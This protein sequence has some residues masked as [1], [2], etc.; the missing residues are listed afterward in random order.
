MYVNPLRKLADHVFRFFSG[1]NTSYL[2][3]TNELRMTLDL[4][5]DL[6]AEYRSLGNISEIKNREFNLNTLNLYTGEYLKHA[7]GVYR[8]ME[9]TGQLQSF[10]YILENLKKDI[11]NLTNLAIFKTFRPTAKTT[12]YLGLIAFAQKTGEL[13]NAYLFLFHREL[14]RNVQTKNSR[15]S[16]RTFA[17][18][19]PFMERRIK[20]DTAE[21]FKVLN[22]LGHRVSFDILD[23]ITKDSKLAGFDPEL[24]VNGAENGLFSTAINQFS[25]IPHTMG[26][27][28]LPSLNLVSYLGKKYVDFQH[29]RNLNREYKKQ[30]IENHMNYLRMVQ[31]GRDPNSPEYKKT[32]KA[33][34]GYAEI[35]ADLQQDIDNYYKD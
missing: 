29:S 31:E 35:I 19:F 11:E 16:Q 5:T 33:L 15:M 25:Y 17:K 8:R 7:H 9:S 10:V 28:G 13:F 12:A 22:D 27:L 34:E 4:L 1:D 14:L 32:E 6:I 23:A 30:Y 18:E 20:A 2:F 3:F 24:V 26:I 21:V